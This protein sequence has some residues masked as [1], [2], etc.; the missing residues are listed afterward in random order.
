MDCKRV[1]RCE[2]TE[3]R[4]ADSWRSGHAVSYGCDRFL[5]GHHRRV[6]WGAG[7]AWAVWWVRKVMTSGKPAHRELPPTH[8]EAMLL[9][10]G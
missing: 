1:T 6:W 5:C 4:T 2:W 8:G 10:A 7:C 3:Y 9:L